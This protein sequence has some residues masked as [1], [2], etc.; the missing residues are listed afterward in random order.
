MLAAT[1]LTAISRPRSLA[2]YTRADIFQRAGEKT[3]AFVRF[4]TVAGSKGSADLAR[5]VRGSRSSSIR[6]KAT[7]TLSATTSRCSS[8]RTRSSFPISFTP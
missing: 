3:P 7:G 1:A 8:S 5:D 4:S 6:R 2:K